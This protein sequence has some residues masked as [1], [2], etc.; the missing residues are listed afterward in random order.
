[1]NVKI[2]KYQK[3]RLQGIYSGNTKMSNVKSFS[4]SKILTSYYL[5]QL[6][7]LKRWIHRCFFWNFQNAQSSYS[8]EKPGIAASLLSLLLSLLREHLI[9]T[10]SQNDQ[11]LGIFLCSC[12]YLFNFDTPFLLERPKLYITHSSTNCINF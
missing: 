1:M 3:K 4:L 8:K 9:I 11:R 10:L 2:L 12:L 6:Y 7:L 5:I